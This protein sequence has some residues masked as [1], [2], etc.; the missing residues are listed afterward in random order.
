MAPEP[1]NKEMLKQLV[2]DIASITDVVSSAELSEFMI[3]QRG[4]NKKILENYEDLNGKRNGKEGVKTDVRDLKKA[5][6]VIKWAVVVIAG[7]G[8]A[9]ATGIWVSNLLSL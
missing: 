2:K 4:M 3:I 5:F 9:A 8:L 6:G 7:S 1:T